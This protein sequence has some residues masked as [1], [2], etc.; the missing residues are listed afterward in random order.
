MSGA[1]PAGARAI[2]RPAEGLPMAGAGTTGAAPVLSLHGT[3]KHYRNTVAVH[4]VSLE[5][6][7]GEF[8]TLLGPSGSGKST[9]IHVIAGFTEPTRGDVW[10]Q[11]RSIVGIPPHRRNIGVVFQNYALFPHMTA[12]DNVAFSLRMR[13]E[14][15]RAIDAKV[16]D[17]L[18]L[19]G[20]AEMGDRY[21]RQLSGGQQQRVALSRALVFEPQLLLMDEP[22]AALDKRLR[23][24]LQ[25]DIV[26]I[27]KQLEIAVLY[28]THDQE[29]A[30]IMS[31]T[32]AIMN[33]GRLMQVGTPQELYERP[34]SAFVAD[35]VGDSNILHGSID[36][37]RECLIVE[38]SQTEIPVNLDN[39]REDL[40]RAGQRVAVMVRP[41][42]VRMSTPGTGA[43]CRLN[44]V[45]ENVA[46]LGTTMRSIVWVPQ[47]NTR[48]MSTAATEA[49][50]AAGAG[51]DVAVSW[52]R[53]DCIVITD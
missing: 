38:D 30:F 39:V 46:Y 4:D 26:R 24:R 16:R 14:K 50:A 45:V 43:E 31:D 10:L 51:A 2:Q 18:G 29:E 53:G 35:F 11:G 33:E 25:G 41:N 8:V 44:G 40:V 19:V 37:D 23:D 34:A 48:I 47:I 5:V 27:Q 15:K 3:A 21:P 20:L 32:I 1:E 28:V 22:L 52:D 13:R 7:K 17:A 49:G 9:L 6:M 42:R 36:W 12:Y